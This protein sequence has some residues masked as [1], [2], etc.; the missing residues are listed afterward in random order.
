M[1]VYS[2]LIVT[3]WRLITRIFIFW[4]LFCI[5][6]CLYIIV[7]A[8]SVLVVVVRPFFLLRLR[9]Q[10]TTQSP[11]LDRAW[12][13]AIFLRG[14]F[15]S[16]PWYMFWS[17]SSPEISNEDLISFPFLSSFLDASSGLLHPPRFRLPKI[18]FWSPSSTGF[19]SKIWFIFL[20]FL[21]W[22]FVRTGNVSEPGGSPRFRRFL[23]DS[24]M[25]G[26]FYVVSHWCYLGFKTRHVV[27]TLSIW[28]VMVFF[29]LVDFI[30]VSF[31]AALGIN[32]SP[33]EETCATST[34]WFLARQSR[35]EGS[36]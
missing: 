33:W 21:S 25:G 35:Y 15:F 5:F 17:P 13:P 34:L 8:L 27:D 16:F 19:R 26:L 18:G 12:R 31:V 20:F 2:N 30:L 7:W 22:R 11:N 29:L 36:F 4:I 28:S 1:N 14:C 3:Q 6:L 24:V 23:C 32:A 9:L 10:E